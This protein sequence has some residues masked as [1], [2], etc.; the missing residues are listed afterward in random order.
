[1]EYLGEILYK[2]RKYTSNLL[3]LDYGLV[4][5]DGQFS[6]HV[7]T[8]VDVSMHFLLIPTKVYVVSF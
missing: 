7:Y 4:D 2:L 6:F 5:L 1:M 3:L 8:L